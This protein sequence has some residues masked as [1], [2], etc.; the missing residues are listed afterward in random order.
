MDIVWDTPPKKV[1]RSTKWENVRQA[2]QDNPNKWAKLYEGPQRNAH[3]LAGRL[4]SKFGTHY[5]VRSQSVR[6]ADGAKVG[7]VWAR[8][9]GPGGM[10]PTPETLGYRGVNGIV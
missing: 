10:Y 7:G 5:E 9:V 4:R 8:Y 1:S 2:L 6:D 3:S